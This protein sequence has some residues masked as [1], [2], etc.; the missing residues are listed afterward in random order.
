MNIDT[1]NQRLLLGVT[2]EYGIFPHLDRLAHSS[3][4]FNLDFGLNELPLDPGILLI[5]GARQYGKS[6]WLE[7]QLKETIVRFGPGS[8]FYLNGDMLSSA[9]EFRSK[10][11]VLTESFPP[12]VKVKRIFIDETTMIPKWEY[13]LKHLVDRG[14][15]NDVL[16]VTTG[17]K[18]T[19][20]RRGAE[21]LPGRKGKHKRSSYLFTPLGYREFKR[22]CG[23]HL[24]EKTLLAYLLSGGS[25]VAGAEL[26]A[27]GSLPEYVI[28]LVR[29][30]IE[31]EIAASGRQRSALLNIAK[32]LFRFGGTAVG[33][34]K[35]AREAG[36]A[37]NTVAAG[38]I[39]LLSDL[40]C[41]IPAYPFDWDRQ[42]LMLRKPCKYHFTNLL[43]AVAY[44]PARVRTVD[45][46]KQ[47]SWHDQGNW[48]EWV[49]AQEL[50]RRSALQG[51]DL[52]A[53]L[54]FWQSSEHEIDF[55]TFEKECIEVKRGNAGPFEFNWFNRQFNK[56]TLIV[57]S[58]HHF[59]TKT[60]RGIT[61]EDFL[62]S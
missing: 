43:V 48:Y 26:A 23:T 61:L 22:V 33:Q 45:D 39:E 25:P 40:G 27:T 62:L 59:E 7:G 50:I 29:D 35:L 32:T 18:A 21:K 19:D 5:R 52:L 10:L 41:V 53:P 49:V 20:L 11:L 30:W 14:K 51:V 2:D 13:V 46:W 8:A 3:F 38:F 16:L 9:E 28:E 60:L 1:V 17:S 42:I 58:N 47:L 34:A 24:G 31:G 56:R 6:T 54:A 57:I 12:N 44:H 37:N 36:L 4:I 55:V 15:L